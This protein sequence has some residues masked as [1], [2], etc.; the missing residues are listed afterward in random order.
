[1]TA[2]YGLNPGYYRVIFLL[3]ETE[4]DD[5][6]GGSSRHEDADRLRFVSG[7]RVC[8][9]GSSSSACDLSTF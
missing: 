4:D 5:V 3:A 1:M 8:G 6:S 7:S 9:N 2:L